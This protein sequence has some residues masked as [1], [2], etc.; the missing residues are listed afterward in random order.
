MTTAII[1][2]AV[3]AVALIVAGVVWYVTSS[4][5]RTKE[6][7]GRFGSEY[8]YELSRAGNRRQVEAELADREKRVRKL[9][10][11][12]LPETQRGEFA[13]RWRD[14]QARF[15]D[16]PG[17]AVND[18]QQLVDQVMTARGYPTGEFGQRA[19][20]VSVDHPHVMAQYRAA[21]EITQRDG[22]TDTEE[23]RQAMVHYRALFDELLMP[24]PVGAR[25]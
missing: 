7:R 10:I 22:Q 16:D 17:S 11:R 1:I 2:I 25:R 6:L 21:Y 23:Q 20:D 9:D 14:V 18:A 8:D 15:V 19:R 24:E 13:Q 3:V 4:R 5:N 12:P